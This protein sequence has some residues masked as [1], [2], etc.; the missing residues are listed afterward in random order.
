MDSPLATASGRAPSAS[1]R[2][3]SWVG[4]LSCSTGTSAAGYITFS[5][6]H[7]PWSRPRRPPGGSR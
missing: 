3:L 5:G 2:V 7:A 6:T 4:M 1:S